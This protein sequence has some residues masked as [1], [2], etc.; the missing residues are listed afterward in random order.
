MATGVTMTLTHK[1]MDLVVLVAQLILAYLGNS[2]HFLTRWAKE[3]SRI[4]LERLTFFRER[5]G[6][7]TTTILIFDC[8][9]LLCKVQ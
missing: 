4:D 1:E 9:Y 7:G 5:M 2:M 8:L 3:L 6:K